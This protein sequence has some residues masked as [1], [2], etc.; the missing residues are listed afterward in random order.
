MICRMR[1]VW[2]ASSEAGLSLVELMFAMVILVVAI[3]AFLQG[4]ASGAVGV[5]DSRQSYVAINAARS[6]LEELKG[7]PFQEILANFGPGSPNETFPVTYKQEGRTYELERVGKDEAG[8]IIFYTDETSIPA[9]FGWQGAYDLNG[10]GDADDLDVAADYKLL[11]AVVRVSWTD[12]QGRKDFEIPTVLF[13][14]KY[15]NE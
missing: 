2:D 9:S 5:G 10:D 3:L 14:P 12:A 11:P 1:Q 8:Q 4:L 7:Y 13:D 6:K 15:P